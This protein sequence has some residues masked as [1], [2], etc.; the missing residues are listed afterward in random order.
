MKHF[1]SIQQKIIQMEKKHETREL[2]LQQ[3]VKNA[4]QTATI[5]MD[6]EVKKW[7][8]VVESKNNEIQRFRAELDSILDVLKLLQKQG[9]VIPVSSAIS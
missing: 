6:Q 9:V 5:E 2:E 1:E 3:I 7:K 4:K 8:A